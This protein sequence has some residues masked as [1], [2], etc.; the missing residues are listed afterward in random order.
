VTAARP[1]PGEAEV[2]AVI[3]RYLKQRRRLRE[4]QERQAAERQQL[5]AYSA[6]IQHILNQQPRDRF[7][8]ISPWTGRR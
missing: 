3:G 7:L 2:R 1:N 6:A 4:I 5:A 8:E